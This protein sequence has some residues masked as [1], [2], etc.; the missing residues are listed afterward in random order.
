M[1]SCTIYIFPLSPI[2][3]IEKVPVFSNFTREHSASLYQ[4]LLQNSL[5]IL[6]PVNSDTQIIVCFDVEDKDF[7][8]EGLDKNFT[9]EFVRSREPG[10]S[11]EMLN[12]KYFGSS[13]CNIVIFSNIIGFSKSDLL[14]YQERLNGDEHVFV[15]GKSENNKVAL[16]SFNTM[17]GVLTGMDDFSIRFDDFL[18]LGCKSDSHLHVLDAPPVI[19][20]L[21][22]FRKLYKNLSKKESLNYCSHQIHEQ[23]TNL[24]IEYKDL[25]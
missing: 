12:R 22:D 7:I 19:S 24:F 17:P 15:I 18:K 21:D 25:L 13:S 16:L 14:S 23:F 4:T 1:K 3:N 8:P 9:L 6:T 10:I 2:Y 11:F 5:E 20:N